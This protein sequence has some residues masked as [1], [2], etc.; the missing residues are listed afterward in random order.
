MNGCI[1]NKAGEIF[2]HELHARFF[3]IEVA[4]VV[5][6]L[7]FAKRTAVSYK[8]TKRPVH[9]F[10]RNYGVDVL[11]FG[12]EYFIVHLKISVPQVLADKDLGNFCGFVSDDAYAVETK[13]FL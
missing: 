10:K 6:D 5:D 1:A 12:F 9:Y 13:F 8:G 3:K 4:N 7:L 11:K 2:A